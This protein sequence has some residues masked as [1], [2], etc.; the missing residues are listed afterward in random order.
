MQDFPGFFWR[1][2]VPVDLPN[3]NPP[4]SPNNNFLGGGFQ[5]F[6]VKKTAT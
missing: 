1:N 4:G 3:S 5:D 2:S 6:K